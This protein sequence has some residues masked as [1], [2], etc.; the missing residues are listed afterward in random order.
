MASML[1]ASSVTILYRQIGTSI[2]SFLVE[3]MIFQQS[4]GKLEP[5][6]SGVPATEYQLWI[7]CC[8]QSVGRIVRKIDIPWERLRDA[9][10]ILAA[11]PEEFAAFGRTLSSN[12]Q[13]KFEEAI[14]SIGATSLSP[15]QAKQ[16]ARVRTDYAR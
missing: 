9:T 5:S 13:Q 2:S 8:K 7:E 10:T 6:E 4:R 1:P 3:R 14:E 15:L 12:D 16:I 11:S